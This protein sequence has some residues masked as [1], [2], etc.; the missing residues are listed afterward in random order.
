M[1]VP[2]RVRLVQIKAGGFPVRA[3]C[4][5]GRDCRICGEA[6]EGLDGK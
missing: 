6:V 5:R 1:I 3:K 2:Y 4:H